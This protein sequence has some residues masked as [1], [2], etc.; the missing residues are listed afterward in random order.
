MISEL[1]QQ[2]GGISFRETGSGN[3]R[4]IDGIFIDCLDCEIL[5]RILNVRISNKGM[6]RMIME[7]PDCQAQYEF[8]ASLRRTKG[9]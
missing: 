6:A 7:C 8:A 3:V 9:Q 5:L 4:V 1:R 2:P